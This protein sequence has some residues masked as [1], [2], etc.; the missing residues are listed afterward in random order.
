MNLD[1]IYNMNTFRSYYLIMQTLQ[2]R[3]NTVI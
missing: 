3:A 2:L 1:K